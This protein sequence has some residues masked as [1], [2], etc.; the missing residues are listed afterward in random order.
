MSQP[1]YTVKRGLIVGALLAP[2]LLQGCGFTVT[3]PSEESGSSTVSTPENN[4]GTT[5]ATPPGEKR[6]N[7]M[8]QATYKPEDANPKLTEAQLAFAIDLFRESDGAAPGTNRLLS[9]I[10]V[11][12]AL[13]M[14]ANGA[15]GETQAEML[16]A[17]HLD[18]LTGDERNRSYRVLLDL[19]THSGE[20]ARV[21][22]ANSLWGNER[23]TFA[24]S[25]L[26]SARESFDAE[27]A[28]V[29][30]GAP[31]TPKRINDW[32]S[33]QTEGQI[34]SIVEPPLD[35]DTI[36]FLL[37]AVYLDA[38]WAYPFPEDNTSKRPFTRADGMSEEV[39]MMHLYEQLGYLEGDGFE[40]VRLPY[41][42]QALSMYLFLPA[43]ST[44]LEGWLEQ[45]TPDAW[46]GWLRDFGLA[47]G[48]LRLPKFTAED[49]IALN[50]PLE[51]LGMKLALDRDRADFSRMAGDPGDIYLHEAKHKATI[52][53]NEKGTIA[54]AVTSIEIRPSSAPS[55]TFELEFNRPF[56]YAIRDERTGV[57]LFMGTVHTL[58]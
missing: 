16:R 54:A 23:V 4:G 38:N 41:K 7:N 56:F 15:E 57:L 42:D 49:E 45:L 21:L 10:S 27:I 20:E 6:S 32:V 46:E 14:T 2:L 43:P 58:Q 19:L 39:D 18:G 30:M 51:A 24:D 25:F 34:D 8:E 48:D 11:A 31:E 44:S 33:E 55:E 13:A 17:L 28:A 47:A 36:M 12:M 29:D 3:G 40:A 50:D 52:K 22:I 35:P 53:V 26:S 9:P 5:G 1:Y 37:N